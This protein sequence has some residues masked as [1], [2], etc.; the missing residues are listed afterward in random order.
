MGNHDSKFS[1][2]PNVRERHSRALYINIPID[3]SF[4]ECFTLLPC[5]CDTYHNSA[6]LSIIIDDLDTLESHIGGGIFL[7]VSNQMRGWMCKV[8]LLVKGPVPIPNTSF[9]TQEVV[10]GYQILFLDFEEGWGGDIKRLGAIYT[11]AVPT[12]TS[13][14][15]VSSGPSGASIEYDLN[16]EEKYSAEM[17]NPKDSSPLVVI[18]GKLNSNLSPE[19]LEFAKFVINRPHKFLHQNYGTPKAALA[20]SPEIG[21]GAQFESHNCVWLEAEHINLP[22]LSRLDERISEMVRQNL[23]EVKCFIQPSY[24]LVDHHNTAL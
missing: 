7:N 15:L 13:Q 21:E 3:K 18:S 23:A 4:V 17:I 22:I 20:Y 2:S 24:T 9:D 14:F 12:T 19:Q 16:H 10:S 1:P 6:W 11:Q 8:N 5:E